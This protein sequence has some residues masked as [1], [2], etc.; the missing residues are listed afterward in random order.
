M[1]IICI[2]RGSYGYS[3][4][5]MEKLSEKTGY[6]IISREEITDKATEFGIPIGKLEM[7]I[8]KNQNL[9]KIIW[10][11]LVIKEQSVILFVS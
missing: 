6:A 4:E 7:M 11:W 5:V 1:Q 8:L 10:V 2:S 3:S 9:K